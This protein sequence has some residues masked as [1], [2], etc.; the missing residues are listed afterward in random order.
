MHN[1]ITDLLKE[2]KSF[3]ENL[4]PISPLGLGISCRVAITVFGETILTGIAVGYT[5]TVSKG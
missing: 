2:G 4:F 1:Q 3:L 5:A